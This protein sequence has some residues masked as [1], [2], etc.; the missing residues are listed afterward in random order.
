MSAILDIDHVQIASSGGCETE[1][2]RFFG[3]LLG[4]EEIEKPEPLHGLAGVGSESGRGGRRIG[5]EEPFSPSGRSA[6]GIFRGR[7]LHPL[8]EQLE[9]AGVEC[10]WDDALAGVQAIFR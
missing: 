8:F 3:E 1:A 5:I 6:S 4:L 2:R 9:E 7:S 10:T